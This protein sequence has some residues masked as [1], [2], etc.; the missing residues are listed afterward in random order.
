MTPRHWPLAALLALIP[1]LRPA[2]AASG[3]HRHEGA[4]LRQIGLEQ[5]TGSRQGLHRLR[6]GQPEVSG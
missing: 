5:A 3:L 6:P 1:P 2:W 4:E